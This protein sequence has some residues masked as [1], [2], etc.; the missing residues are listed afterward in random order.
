MLSSDFHCKENVW[1]TGAA[2]VSNFATNSPGCMG[3]IRKSNP[4]HHME[5]F[6]ATKKTPQVRCNV[7]I[8]LTAF[9][10]LL[11]AS[12][13]QTITNEYYGDVLQC[14]RDAVRHQRLELWS[15]DNWYLHHDNPPAHSLHLTQTFLAKNQT[16]V[17]C[18]APY[19]PNM[20]VPQTL[21]AI[22]RQAIADK[23]GHY[24]CNDS[25]AKHHSERGFL[26]MFPTMAVLLGCVWSP[27]ETALRVTRFP[28]L[29]VC[30]FFSTARRSDTFLTDLV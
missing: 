26:G 6:L 12:K 8:M 10:W 16:P 24:D 18:Q 22:G 7:K 27:K 23:R 1:M 14:L 15:T 3:K 21:E 19:S 17:V 13:G 20:A 29:Q 4:I 28:A 25:R 9:L 5:A 11:Y 2:N 30:L